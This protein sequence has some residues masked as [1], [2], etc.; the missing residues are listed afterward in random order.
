MELHGPRVT[1]EKKRT[2]LGIAWISVVF[3]QKKGLK[4]DYIWIR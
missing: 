3:P 4:M 1:L 2:E